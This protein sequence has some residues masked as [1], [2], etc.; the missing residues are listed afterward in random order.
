MSYNA[1]Y[2]KEFKLEINFLFLASM[3][4]TLIKS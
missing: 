1:V 4:E 3:I 2:L